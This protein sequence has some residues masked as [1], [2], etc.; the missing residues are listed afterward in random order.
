MSLPPQTELSSTH[1]FQPVAVESHGPV[2]DTTAS[3]L[4]ELVR[5]I[6]DLSGEPFEARFLF[7]RVSVL[8]QPFNF[9]VIP[10]NFPR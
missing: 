10:R 5:K 4:E 6:T 9:H 8:V 2:S 3:F 7:R 1:E